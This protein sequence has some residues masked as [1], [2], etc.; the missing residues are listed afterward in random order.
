MR[1]TKAALILSL[2]LGLGIAAA[3]CE[4]G[5]AP[6]PK[7]SVTALMLIDMQRDFLQPNGRRPVAQN[8][9]EPMIKATNAM[10]DAM[11]KAPM[12]VIY[13]E[14]EFSP[15]QFVFGLSNDWA[16]QRYEAGSALDPRIDNWA[17]VYFGK[18][19]KNAFTNSQLVTHLKIIDCGTLVVAGVYADAC[20]LDTVEH[21]LKRGYNVVV[22]SD[23]VAAA[24]D[25][26]RDNALN[27]MKQAGAKIETSGEF[28]SSLGS[29]QNAT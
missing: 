7:G 10:I 6:E 8:Q 21:A 17:G 12:P 9:V 25:Q 24:S 16:A 5:P 18:A 23:A 3:G 14:N 26:A 13:I 20:V 19:A 1:P 28:I 15:F 27:R 4:T 22:I 2:M 11:R 29:G